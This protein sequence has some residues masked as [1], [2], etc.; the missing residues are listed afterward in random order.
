MAE[1]PE[2]MGPP[3]GGEFDSIPAAGFDDGNTILALP[4]FQGALEEDSSSLAGYYYY[5]D[6]DDDD[7]GNES[8]SEEGND[9]D[10]TVVSRD[11][12]TFLGQPARF[13]SY[14]GTAGF[15]RISFSAA[16]APPLAGADVVGMIVVHYRYYRFI[17]RTRGGG[18]PP[19]VEAP[20]YGTDVH[21]VRFLVP[22][23]AIAA[24]PAAALRLAGA[25]LAAD[26]YPCRAR[27]RLQELWSALLAAAPVHVV[28]PPPPTQLVVTVDV[29]ALVR[30]EDRTRENVE[31]VIA[32]LAAEARVVDASPAIYGLEQPLPAP[33]V[34]GVLPRAAKRR[35]VG[36]VAVAAAAGEE[37]GAA[38]V[39]AICCDVMLE[40][41]G[42]LA[43]WPRCGH[44]FHGR[45]LERLLA[46]V[47]HSCPLCRNTL[48]V[49]EG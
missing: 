39:C 34:C 43:A 48:S 9:S 14:Q 16:D 49:R 47:R 10:D 13:A 28:P 37:E 2:E 42:G 32:A 1:E 23:A 22:A 19:G 5:D 30:R 26:V 33:V 3:F 21:H 11:V 27:A 44:V 41:Q 25:S 6:I 36:D 17:S 40:E 7:D 46:T 20:E 12:T 31:R 4:S 15:M 18:G 45:C 8:E 38:E 24:D 29:G 35:R